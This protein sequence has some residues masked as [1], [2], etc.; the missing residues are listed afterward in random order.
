VL[1]LAVAAD[2]VDIGAL[3]RIVEIGEAG[4]VELEIGAAELV[5]RRDLVGVDAGE[6]VPERIHLGIDARVD[7]GAAAAVVQH[8]R[9]RDRQLGRRSRRRNR[10]EIGEIVAEDRPG[11]GEP[12]GDP[13]RRRAERH[14]SGLVLELDMQLPVAVDHAADLIEE[15]HVP[16]AAAHLAV[17][18][19][20]QPERRLAPHRRGDRLVLDGAQFRRGEPPRLM[21]LP[22]L[23]QLRRAQQAADMIGA[24]RRAVHQNGIS[25]SRSLPGARLRPPAPPPMARPGASP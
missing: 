16:R 2:A 25:S 8:R 15:I 4:V 5:Q 13:V 17:G 24:E 23:Q 10:F 18:D 1:A 14:R 6:I 7:G 11:E 3:G 12:A 20:A 19:P 22:R 21:L 9:R